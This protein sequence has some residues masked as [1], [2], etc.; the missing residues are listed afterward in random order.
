MRGMLQRRKILTSRLGVAATAIAC[1]AL[2][3]AASA[4]TLTT[5]STGT[6]SS[7][8]YAITYTLSATA[9]TVTFTFDNS[10]ATAAQR[11]RIVNASPGSAVT[12]P[13]QCTG[14]NT[15][16]LL[17]VFCTDTNGGSGDTTN[18][19][20]L[21][22]NGS[23]ATDSVNASGTFSYETS[24]LV[25]NLLDGNETLN[26]SN[27]SRA[28]STYA[29]TA[30][31]GLGNDTLTGSSGADT[32]T[33]NDG[34]DI[35]IG[36]AGGDTF[37]GNNGY[38]RVDY[39][40]EGGGVGGVTVTVNNTANDTDTFGATNDNVTDTIEF[41]T[42]TALV[43]TMTST[44]AISGTTGA[45]VPGRTF[46]GLGGNDVLTGGPSDDY[47]YGGLGNDT[48]VGNGGTDRVAY[49]QNSAA[50]PINLTLSS[51]ANGTGTD[52][53]GGTD[54]LGTTNEVY[55]GGSGN[56]IINGAAVTTAL[57]LFGGA[58]DD[59]LTG[60]TGVDTL[61][62]WLGNDTLNCGAS[63]ADFHDGTFAGNADATPPINC[64][65]LVTAFVR[66]QG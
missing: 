13:T 65:Q 26:L 43:D 28:V 54:S 61:R 25:L 11:L 33:G 48:M 38:D 22:F 12:L 50:E 5:A 42:G 23:S 62:G 15:A 35:L 24:G 66:Y 64:E 47:F 27:V 52:G 57:S 40:A 37:N 41:I 49:S 29:L 20:G 17:D 16:S 30:D 2:P 6:G 58:G 39:A 4:D 32:L 21:T 56:D 45:P 36:K 10:N 14:T 7:A 51:A 55:L 60:G 8:G 53:V 59:T 34:N 3:A 19:R 1:L 31:G 9:G 18:L 44:N 46:S 63:S